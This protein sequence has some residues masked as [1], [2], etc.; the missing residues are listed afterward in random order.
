MDFCEKLQTLR[1]EKGLS[2]EALAELLGVSRQAV[3]KWESGGAY[4]ETDKI[5]TLCDL[6]GVTADELLRGGASAAQ[7]VPP[8]PPERRH[9]R[10][11]AFILAGALTLCVC[12]LLVCIKNA[13][14][15]QSEA[16]RQ[17]SLA[18]QLQQ[19][20]DLRGGRLQ[21][22]REETEALSAQLDE[23][24]AQTAAAADEAALLRQ[25]RGYY[26]DFARRWRLD[27]M[28]YFA[29]G[30]APRESA[31][32]LMWCFAVNLD[33]WSDEEKG[34]MSR[35]YVEQTILSH[36]PAAPLSHTPLRKTWNFD[37]EAY[38]A[39]A[40]GMNE[41]PA[42]YLTAWRCRLSDQDV[43]IYEIELAVYEPS[44]LE[45]VTEDER[46]APL[47]ED[48]AAEPDGIWRHTRTERISYCVALGQ[49]VFLS[50]ELIWQAE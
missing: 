44:V 19:E 41:P 48:L 21:S 17:S 14:Q 29:E 25:S 23:A 33:G 32:Y 2:Q 20:V 26:F 50:H 3:S 10:W 16:A 38:T 12:L 30:E 46:I 39:V 9:I 40:G 28:P 49:P 22:L 6:F 35:D 36:F 1:R 24:R 4:P 47:R 37:G 42:C 18:A 5:L 13:R 8:S 45:S 43:Q 34:T 31:E 15:A 27:Y 7:A 11:A